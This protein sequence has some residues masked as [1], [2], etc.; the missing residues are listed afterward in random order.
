MSAASQDD[1]KL[2]AEMLEKHPSLIDTLANDR[3]NALHHAILA[4]SAEVVGLLLAATADCVHDPASG[5]TTWSKASGLLHPFKM[6]DS[7]D[8]SSRTPLMCAGAVG[9]EQIVQQLLARKPDLMAEDC[10]GRTA[11]LVATMNNHFKV[12]EMLLDANPRLVTRADCISR[13]G[14]HWV[15]EF[16]SGVELLKRILQSHPGLQHEKDYC[17][18]EP[19]F[20]AVGFLFL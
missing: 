8:C 15:A 12:A 2:V 18:M 9:D 6:I 11:F 10:E 17:D 14:L 16:P 5:R 7:S 19:F 4:R 13:T 1:A 20:I 3:S